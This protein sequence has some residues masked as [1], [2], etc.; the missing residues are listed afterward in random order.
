MSPGTVNALQGAT[1]QLLEVK[2]R[3]NAERIHSAPDN[4]VREAHH[5][6]VQDLK[7]IQSVRMAYIKRLSITLNFISA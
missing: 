6:T 2:N 7:S 1:E 3:M 4:K 5:S